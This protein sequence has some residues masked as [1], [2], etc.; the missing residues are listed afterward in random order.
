MVTNRRRPFLD[1]FV[2]R[3]VALA[4][5]RVNKKLQTRV[6]PEDVVQSVMD[7]VFLRMCGDRF[8]IKES[9]DL[10]RLLAAIL[11]KK[12]W[13]RWN[14][15]GRGNATWGQDNNVAV[16]LSGIELQLSAIAPPL[17]VPSRLPPVI[18]V[19]PGPNATRLTSPSSPVSLIVF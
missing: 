15:P 2:G 7:S 14:F 11:V 13:G 8:E 1:C 17:S 5:S 4:G 9:G 19:S 6:A 3:L 10:W 12:V 16:G 18:R